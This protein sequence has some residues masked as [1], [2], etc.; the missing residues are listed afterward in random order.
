MSRERIVSPDDLPE[1]NGG[2]GGEKEWNWGL[3]P[4]SLAEYTGQRETVERLKIAIDA[5]K[6]RAES[7]DHLLLYGP[8]GLGKCI[9]GDSLIQTAN[10][11]LVPFKQLLP[12]GMKP[13]ESRPAHIAVWGVDGPEV[14]THFYYSG[15]VPTRKIRTQSGFELEGTPHHPVLVSSPAGP[16]W[17]T[18]GELTSDDYVAVARGANVW[19]ASKS[20]T[21]RPDAPRTR[22]EASERCT[23]RL[24]AEL[25]R[26][27]ER[28][29]TTRELR[30]GWAQ[31]HKTGESP[32]AQLTA[33]RLGLPLLDGHLVASRANLSLK[34]PAARNRTRAVPLTGDM[35]YLLGV[36]IGDGH[37]EKGAG[38]PA[39]VITCDEAAMQRELGRVSERIFGHAPEVKV[40]G[41]KT[42]R[43][44]WP[45]SCGQV[46]ADFGVEAVNAAHKR[47]PA[48]ILQGP[49][50]AAIGF[51]QGLF[52]ADGHARADGIELGL[53][54]KELCREVQLMLANLGVIASLREK[55]VADEPFWILW[56]GGVNASMF[57]EKV[58]FRL[59]RKRNAFVATENPGWTRSELVPHAGA[60]LRALLDAHLPQ[61][62]AVHKAFDHV[63]RGDRVPTRTQIEKLINLLPLEAM[64]HSAAETLRALCNEGICWERVAA[65]ESSENEAWDFVVPKT[66][67]FV[68]N[69]LY[70]HNTTL[71]LIVAEELGRDIALT[72]GPSLERPGDVMGF[73]V[74][75]KEGDII[76]IDEIHR[77]PRIVE[78]FLYSAMEDYIVNFTLDKGM[79]S[80]PLPIR[81]EKFTI[82]GATTRPAML[83][84]PLRDRFG[85]QQHFD[86]YAEADL[87][88]IVQRSAFILQTEIDIESAGEI[89]RRSRG[90]PR[91]A[92]RL[93][94]RV[95]DYALVRAN[96]NITLDVAREALKLE[97][98]DG[99]GLDRLDRAVLNIIKDVYEGGPVGIEALAATLNEE[100]DTLVDVVEPYLLKIGF[101]ART[102]AGRR[103]TRR[104]Y[105][106]LGEP[107]PPMAYSPQ[108]TLLEEAEE[109]EERL[110]EIKRLRKRDGK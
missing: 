21:Y 62:R 16:T 9:T 55:T 43:M 12:P 46:C 83:T 61:T 93:L 89:A 7:L 96:G 53:R 66:H 50:A 44:S 80:K 1:D 15:R 73:L 91:V 48:A 4:K 95:R 71:A 45:K 6:A 97:G 19:G 42:A 54:S 8:P 37:V 105:E 103:I 49:R 11:G 90:T 101:L 10:R 81:L 108:M 40:Y 63:K 104:A 60:A 33:Q 57:L 51:L 68:A 26:I 29:P 41:D 2:S 86:F 39:F 76:F 58:G 17:K 59:A 74:N 32:T 34:S 72:S 20:A 85:L 110:R 38:A 70:N 31:I 88:A 102:P 106:Y 82:I 18:L 99:L 98:I 79:Y 56:I 23:R 47:V 13:G 22:R 28:T 69:G 25:S 3:R 24:H 27:L 84:R 36:L 100:S 65:V 67:S 94:R 78:E 109:S 14:A 92:N 35:G 64:L 52:D 77:L 30:A 5:S 107:A 75:A 87:V